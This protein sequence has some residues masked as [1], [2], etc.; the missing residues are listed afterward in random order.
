MQY[1]Q[2]GNLS[3][4]H[5]ILTSISITNCSD[6]ELVDLL[7][8]KHPP[9]PPNAQPMPACSHLVQL[10]HNAVKT[11]LS[12]GEL[13]SQAGCTL[14]GKADDQW[15]WRARE[16]LAPLL[17]ND[18]IGEYLVSHVFEPKIQGYFLPLTD[19]HLI[20]GKLFALRKKDGGICPI[21]IGDSDCK[22]AMKA[23]MSSQ[24]PYLSEFFLTVHPRVPN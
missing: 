4:A 13:V 6:D 15:G 20:G 5:S 9:P 24:T 3:K 22:V 23:L 7:Q 2:L 18:Y 12:R 16:H 11:W 10:D 17:H 21:L 1:A 19:D 8:A 14:A